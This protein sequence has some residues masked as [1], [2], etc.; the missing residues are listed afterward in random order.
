VELRTRARA[1]VP[2][3]LPLALLLPWEIR[4]LARDTTP[5]PPADAITARVGMFV[6]GIRHREGSQLRQALIGQDKIPPL[7]VIVAGLLV[8]LFG[9]SLFALRLGGMLCYLALMVQS[10]DLARRA[11]AGPWCAG[12][13][14]FLCGVSPLVYGWSRLDY[15]DIYVAVFFVGC[16]QVMI[17]GHLNRRRAIALGVLIGCGVLCKLNFLAALC[18]PGLWFVAG[19]LRRGHRAALLLTG[20]AALVVCGWWLGL[21][22]EIVIGNFLD[23]TQAMMHSVPLAERQDLLDRKLGQLALYL[24]DLR[25]VTM[26]WAGAVAGLVLRRGDPGA[27]ARALLGMSSLLALVVLFTFDPGPRYLMPLLAPAAV[28]MALGLERA[29]EAAGGLWRAA[30]RRGSV[31]VGALVALTLLVWFDRLNRI[32]QSTAR[33]RFDGDGMLSP[34]PDYAPACREMQRFKEVTM[35]A[36][37][38]VIEEW[39]V[40]V[41]V[42]VGRR[43]RFPIRRGVSRCALQLRPVGFAPQRPR[44]VDDVS[45]C[46]PLRA[47]HSFAARAGLVLT[48]IK[49]EA[50]PE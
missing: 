23:S 45:R 35:V 21:Q 32:P 40:G 39:M 46:P 16:L 50:T 14:A 12:G 13:A 18:A 42:E 10:Y 26:L 36:D 29:I 41:P 34:I 33:L 20:G 5:S 19:H 25:G 3:L 7:S 48:Q 15:A 37:P 27:P 22:H 31:L 43:C 1:L 8:L 17:R 49:A 4:A 47:L 24:W 38:P 44:P 28:L 9:P 2:L 30:P 11:R 6:E